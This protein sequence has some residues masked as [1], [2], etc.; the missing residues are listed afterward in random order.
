MA[1]SSYAV[2]WRVGGE[3][4]AGRLDVATDR[5]ELHGRGSDVVVPFADVSEAAIVR[6]GA[7]RVRGM[8]A[9]ILRLR[10][11]GCL[12]IASLGAP[13]VLHELAMFVS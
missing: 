12:S 11:G 2:V 8:P 4:A 3:E 6:T 10:M 7:E 5:F 13:G 1:K 9:L